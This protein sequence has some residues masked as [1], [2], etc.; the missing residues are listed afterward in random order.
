MADDDHVA[1][2]EQQEV[3]ELEAIMAKT[4]SLE[5]EE[6]ASKKKGKGQRKK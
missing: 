3:P 4:L 5:A 2:V 6:S 1:E